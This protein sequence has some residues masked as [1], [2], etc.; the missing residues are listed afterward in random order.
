MAAGATQSEIRGFNLTKKRVFDLVLVCPFLLLAAPLML[1]VAL[2]IRL[3]DGRP[4]LFRQVRLG[5]GGAPFEM[6]KF[7]TMRQASDAAHRDYASRWIA[8]GHAFNHGNGHGV[9]TK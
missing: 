4:I 8:L 5:R 9:L 1:L 6:L 3:F 2:A 7:R